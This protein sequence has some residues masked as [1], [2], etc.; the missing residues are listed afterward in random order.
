MKPPRIVW[1]TSPFA[2]GLVRAILQQPDVRAGVG[3]SVWGSVWDSVLDGVWDSVLDSVGDSVWDS[4]WDSVGESVRVSVGESVRASILDSVGV[5]VEDSVRASILDSVWASV[6]AS[7]GDSVRASV[8]A[9]VRSSVWDSVWAS[10]GESVWTSVRAGVLDSVRDSVGD[11]VCAGV[12]ASVWTSVRD[13]VRDSVRDGVR[14]SVWDSGYGQHDAPWLAFHAYFRE[15]CGLVAQ[16][17][18]LNGLMEICKSAG[19][20]LPHEKICWISERHNSLFLDESGR[21]NNLSGPALSYPDG[22][23]IYAVHGVRVPAAVIEQPITLAQ[24]DAET[25]A[26]VRRVMIERYGQDRYIQ[27]SGAKLIHSDGYG[28]LYRK[29][30]RD[31]EPI[32]MVRVVN[33]TPEPDGRC[34]DYWLRVPPHIETAEAAV[35]WT[36]GLEP[37]EYRPAVET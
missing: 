6:R 4:V 35:A 7:V 31:D 26:E 18:P 23:S 17:D 22:F 25:N 10:V 2:S 32:V 14:D 11:S 24:I 19:W 15:V 16:T 36:F 30:V 13:G 20:F 21:L 12:R 9:S 5:S 1:T 28:D 8:G 29:E 3:E 33:S 37:P 27:D 34:K